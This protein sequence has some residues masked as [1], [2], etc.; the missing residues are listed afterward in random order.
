M[1]DVIQWIIVGAIVI[2]AAVYLVKRLRPSGRGCCCE[3]CPRAGSC[4]TAK[5]NPSEC[6]EPERKE[7]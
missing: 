7:K 4:A 5:D 6:P 1:S 3:G 2:A